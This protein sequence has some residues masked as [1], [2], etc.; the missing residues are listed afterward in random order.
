[1]QTIAVVP[2]PWIGAVQF[3]SMQRVSSYF[4]EN[5]S[6]VKRISPN[7]NDWFA[8]LFICFAR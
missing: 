3:G 6:K 2:L 7:K 4:C 1:M 5:N 8:K